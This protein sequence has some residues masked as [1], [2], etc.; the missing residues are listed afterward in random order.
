MRLLDEAVVNRIV[1]LGSDGAPHEPV[2]IQFIRRLQEIE[3]EAGRGTAHRSRDR[4]V[5]P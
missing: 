4:A 5:D 1:D 2:D 3:R